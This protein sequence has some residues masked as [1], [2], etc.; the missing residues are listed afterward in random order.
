MSFT[1]CDISVNLIRW[2][3]ICK[4]QLTVGV[5]HVFDICLKYLMAFPH[6]QISVFGKQIYIYKAT[7]TTRS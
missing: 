5:L 4:R 3:Q 2:S 6:S 7:M 1:V